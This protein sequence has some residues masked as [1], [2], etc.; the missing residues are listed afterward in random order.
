MK[1]RFK[2]ILGVCILAFTFS[3]SAQLIQPKFEEAVK[4]EALNSEAEESMPIPYLNG[5]S[6]YFVRTYIEG[7]SKERKKAQEVWAS[8]R[9]DG[10]WSEPNSLFDHMNDLGNNG[11]IG[12][13]KDGK[14]VYI[15]NSIQTRRKLAKGIAYT[16]MQ[17]DGT[18]SDLK[19]LNIDGFEAGEGYYSFYMN[20][21]E[22]ILLVSMSPNDTTITE[23]LF[24]SLKD[25]SGNWSTLKNLGKTINTNEIELSPYIAD[26]GKTL[27]FSSTGHGGL[28]DADV[29][30][31]YRLDESWTNWSNPIN[32]GKPINSDGFDAYFIIGNNKEVFFTSNRGQKYTEIYSTKIAEQSVMKIHDDVTAEFL[33]QG[34]PVKGATLQIMNADG[35]VVDEVITDELGQFKYQKIN[36]E[37]EHFVQLK[38]DE[39]NEYLGGKVYFLDEEGTRLKRLVMIGDG[40]FTDEAEDTEM[41]EGVFKYNELPMQD[42]GLIVIDE[43][44]YTLDTIYTNE[45]G[46]FRYFKMELEDDYS[47]D[48]IDVEDVKLENLDLY[49]TDGN[50]QRTT[51]FNF[52]EDRGFTPKS[53]DEPLAT[54]QNNDKVVNEEVADEERVKKDNATDAKQSQAKKT[55][56]PKSE[57]KKPE[58][59]KSNPLTLYFNFNDWSLSTTDKTKLDGVANKMANDKNIKATL[60]GHTDDVG[61][62]KINLRVSIYRVRAAR[63]YMME[64][65]IAENRITIFGMGEVQ[66]VATNKTVEGRAQNRRV[67]IELK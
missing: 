51:T 65:G 64:K 40:V 6:L 4:L 31:S 48:P 17:S 42:A 63:A 50:G 24:V 45:K 55:E 47:L 28:G 37:E 20:P 22:D 8:N 15:F 58:T 1:Q 49:L 32:L 56:A 62:A 54:N 11:V 43:N 19:K 38:G 60:T 13:S 57:T 41:I 7:K 5:E 27:Y 39:N 29:F 10:N 52:D 59:A 67:E 18:W 26:D 61:T 12:S 66:P 14:T 53:S 30:V 3:A 35:D 23:D 36:L 25:A 21:S 44:G 46:E 34:L 2:I 16:Q 33:Y 9:S